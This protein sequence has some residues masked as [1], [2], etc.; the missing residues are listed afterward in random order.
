MI[1]SYCYHEMLWYFFLL[2]SDVYD[3]KAVCLLEYRDLQIKRILI[4]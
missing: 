2:V 3:K 1:K 4:F